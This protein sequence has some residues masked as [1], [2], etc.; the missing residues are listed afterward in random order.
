M[1]EK[2]RIQKGMDFYQRRIRRRLRNGT[3]QKDVSYITIHFNVHISE[4]SNR[5]TKEVIVYWKYYLNLDRIKPKVY[6]EKFWKR[7]EDTLNDLQKIKWKGE[8]KSTK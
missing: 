5:Q 4:L 6:K 7:T 3:T 1:E 2:D 8:I